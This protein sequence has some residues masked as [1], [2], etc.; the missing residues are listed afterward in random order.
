M[1]AKIINKLVAKENWDY[2]M[3]FINLRGPVVVG[4]DAKIT[5]EQSSV[6]VI[7][8]DTKQVPGIAPDGA[9]YEHEN[10]INVEDII[11]VDFFKKKKII[12]GN[13]VPSAILTAK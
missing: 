13:A 5:N 12:T 8:A 9:L 1:I 11:S 2:A 6:L 4:L 10:C 7:K 3:I